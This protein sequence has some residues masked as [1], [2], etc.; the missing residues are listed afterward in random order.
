MFMLILI[1]FVA[2]VSGIF[3]L[4]AHIVADMN[5]Q[6]R[7]IVDGIHQEGI[8]ILEE[9]AEEYRNG[10]LTQ[11]E[12]NVYCMMKKAKEFMEESFQAK[13]R[14]REAQLKI[15]QAQINPH[16]LYNTLDA[17]N[18]MAIKMEAVEISSMVNSLARYFRLS[19]SKGEY[20]VSIQDEI[21]LAK[22]YL[23]IQQ[24][25]FKGAIVSEFII[26]QGLEA[27]KMPKLTLQPIIENA[28]LHGIQKKQNRDGKI[29]IEVKK[30]EENICF[31]ITDDGTGMEQEVIN[32]ILHKLPEE[33]QAS[34]GLYNVNERIKLYF[35][36]EYG[37][38]ISSEKGIGTTVKILIKAV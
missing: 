31:W 7:K 1:T 33:K 28:I 2:F 29:R 3:L 6:I 23:T 14:E 16:F 13:L 4:L 26:E 18:W 20:A 27:Y 10:D 35:G 11:L 30:V 9:G 37:I 38:Y 17:I 19:L 34:Y 21:E 8:D 22:A 25:R 32:K 12:Q 36:N 15:L 5:K 24:M